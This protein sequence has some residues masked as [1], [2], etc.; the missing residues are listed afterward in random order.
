MHKPDCRIY[1]NEIAKKRKIYDVTLKGA[2]I[3]ILLLI[4]K[5]IAGIW[6]HS[7]AIMADA[8]HSFSDLL[9]DI[10]VLVSV[11]LGG[12]P[13]DKSHDYGYGKAATVSAAVLG[14]ILL[15]ISLVVFYYGMRDMIKAFQGTILK[16]PSYFALIVAIVSII[17]KEWAYRF[18]IRTAHETQSFAV[19]ANAWP[20]RSDSFSSIGTAIGISGAI[21]LGERWRV[22]DPITAIIV[23]IFILKMALDLFVRAVAELTETSLPD[24]VEEEIAN[25]AT[26]EDGIVNVDQILTRRIGNHVAIEMNIKLPGDLTVREAHGHAQ[27]IENQLKARFGEGTHVGVHIEPNEG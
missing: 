17:L 15:F 26:T 18:T 12:K 22:L 7:S 10:I 21:F 20:H 13:K 11:K 9:T 3:N 4:S 25:I 23:S 1:M 19:A 27:R 6:G 2:V 24:T 5:F 16:R 8:V 14:I